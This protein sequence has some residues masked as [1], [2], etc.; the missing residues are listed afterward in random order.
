MRAKRNFN[1]I[2]KFSFLRVLMRRWNGKFCVVFHSSGS[3]CVTLHLWDVYQ[4]VT[5]M[6][7]WF[8]KRFLQRL[9]FRH[10]HWESAV[11]AW[12][13]AYKKERGLSHIIY[14]Q[15]MLLP[16]NELIWRSRKKISGEIFHPSR[17]S[18][19]HKT[20]DYTHPGFV[21]FSLPHF[22]TDLAVGEV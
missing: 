21:V 22:F 4:V 2:K 15:I 20:L 8:M 1:A 6:F 7:V 11:V 19:K 17:I 10:N 13:R 3:W 5:T 16:K 9:L 12:R 18:L 14:Q